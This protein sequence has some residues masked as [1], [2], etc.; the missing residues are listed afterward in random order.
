MI[1]G[2]SHPLLQRWPGL[3]TTLPFIRLGDFPTPVEHADALAAGLDLASLQIKRD[4]L[5]ASD[6]G[7]NKIRKLEFLLG[8]AI[9]Q[10]RDRVVTFGGLGSNHAI[11]TSLN[12]RK[13]GLRCTAIV[14]PEPVT[15]LV[16][17]TLAR[18]IEL[19]TELVLATDYAGIRATT[20]AV[21]ER[22][23]REHC[24]EV[25]FGGSSAMGALGFVNA[26][27]ELR[28]QVARGEA[29]LP[30]VIYVA[31]G[32]AG[33]VAGLGLG[34]ELA[35]LPTRVE[36]VQVTPD[37]LEP[38]RHSK[39]LIAD[40]IA[41]LASGGVAG[42][43]AAAAFARLTIR[44]DQLGDGYAMPTAAA[45]AAVE[46]WQATVALPVSLTYT[47]K[48]LAGLFAD[49]RA[50]K[51]RDQH[52]LFWNTYNSHPYT[53]AANPDWSTLPADLRELIER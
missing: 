12:C 37:S 49:A 38:A 53:P 20:R 3:A 44:N 48:T 24:Y 14:T 36:A 30:D 2:E 52:A 51:L 33:T 6:Y 42:A 9:A 50:G 17:K 22:H 23:G 32:T 43:D 46:L 45:R 21:I 25:P 26:A 35:G 16:R 41:L 34:L 7:G 18:H 5:A 39:E 10:Q 11:A 29:R 13:L 28:D 4:D 27:L 1:A 31:C 19:G 15:D 8:D 47:A 40:A